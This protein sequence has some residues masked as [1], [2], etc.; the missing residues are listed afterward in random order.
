M[1]NKEVNYPAFCR[2]NGHPH[3]CLRNAIYVTLP[4]TTT[5][6]GR[7]LI[8]VKDIDCVKDLIKLNRWQI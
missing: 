7:T 3:I 5:P 8:H 1:G 4:S 6:Y 2:K